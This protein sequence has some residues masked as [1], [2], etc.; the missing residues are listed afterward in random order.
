MYSLLRSIFYLGYMGGAM[1]WPTL[2]QRYPQ[3]VGKLISG[4]VFSWAAM[5][6]LTRMFLS[7]HLTPDGKLIQNC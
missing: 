7:R 4:A 1:F 3:H 2:V 6:L 5:S